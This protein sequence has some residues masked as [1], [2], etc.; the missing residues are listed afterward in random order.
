LTP[1]PPFSGIDRQKLLGNA[2]IWNWLALYW[3]DNLCPP[4]S[5]GVRKPSKPYNYILSPNYNH[6]PRHALFT[7]WI[8]VDLYGETARFLLS[9]QP[10]AR[11]ELLEQIAARQ[12]YINCRGVIEAAN[13]L[14]YDSDRRTFKRGSTTQ[15]RKGNIRRYIGFLQQLELTYD[16]FTMTGET[17]VKLLPKEYS[18]FLSVPEQNPV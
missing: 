14:Y 18:G 3:F 8:L 16:L 11:G 4:S 7:T 17:I 1:F 6:R 9:K 10:D 13:L 5:G 2:G 15:T 12:Y